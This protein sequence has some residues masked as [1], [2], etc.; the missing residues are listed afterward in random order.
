MVHFLHLWHIHQPITQEERWVHKAV[1]KAY[2]PLLEVYIMHPDIKFNLNVT[3]ALLE[4]LAQLHPETIDKIKELLKNKQ[5]ELTT[6]AYYQPILSIIPIEHGITQIKKNTALIKKTFGIEPSSAW[7]PER[8][9]EEYM[10]EIFERAGVK[11]VLLDE[12]IMKRGNKNFGMKEKYFSWTAN[13]NKYKV[14]IFNIDKKMRYLIPWETTEKVI[15]YI[16]KVENYN[17]ERMV[18]TFGDDGEKMGEWPKT[19]NTHKWL[20][21]FLKKIEKEKIELTTL[22][23]YIYEHGTKGNAIFPY[24]SYSEMEAWAMGNF[25]NWLKHPIVNQ[26]YSRYKL[27]LETSKNDYIYMAECN[28]PY[29]YARRMT[30]H[31]QNIYRNILLAEKDGNEVYYIKENYLEDKNQKIFLDD[32]GRIVE[33]DLKEECYNVVNTSFFAYISEEKALKKEIFNEKLR[34]C[35]TD[36]I[37][38]MPI[39]KKV[40]Y[41]IFEDSLFTEYEFFG[42]EVKKILKLLDGK[43]KVIVLIKNNSK[44]RKTIEYGVEFC[45]TPPTE[46]PEYSIMKNHKQIFDY[47]GNVIIRDPEQSQ[48]GEG[49]CWSCVEDEKNNLV[50]GAVWKPN[51]IK[52]HIRGLGGDG[53]FFRPVFKDREVEF[54]KA[55]EYRFT[56][57]AGSG[58]YEKIKEIFKEVMS[59]N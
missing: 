36:F 9:W 53:V 12:H 38:G 16:R 14:N 17:D 23:E 41:K 5:V 39:F 10:P 28:D 31:R 8:V 40:V 32:T 25:K 49:V 56:L 24:G 1:E 18:I 42:L 51:I 6:T 52:K 11:N 22:D 4:K 46:S 44:E 45:F 58:S 35:I 19:E 15:K 29:W 7:V 55:T 2:N 59:E 48:D 20:D 47:A 27:A 54:G 33:W 21:E 3:G 13:Y 30:Y 50:M 43:L 34:G 57:Y 26:M 37:D